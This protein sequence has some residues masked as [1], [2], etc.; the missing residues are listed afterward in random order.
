MEASKSSPKLLKPLPEAAAFAFSACRQRRSPQTQPRRT[1]H[2]AKETS[3]RPGMAHD[4]SEWSL[5][6]SLQHLEHQAL[7]ERA[8][9]AYAL[10]NTMCA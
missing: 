8:Q 9:P 10:S 5:W 7:D 6:F 1:C 4:C 3:G 2:C